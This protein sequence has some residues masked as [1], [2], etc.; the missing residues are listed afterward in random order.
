MGINP[1]PKQRPIPIWMGSYREVVERV[2]RRIARISDGWM[3]QFPPDEA[4]KDL[5]ER[6]RGYAREAGRDPATIGIECG[7]P[8]RKGDNPETWVERALA[9]KSLGATHLR[10]MTGGGLSPREHIELA[11]RAKETLDK[12]LA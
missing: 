4:F 8:A 10:V 1:L 2:I 7:V 9:Y 12:A 6:F 3:P 11:T 5:M